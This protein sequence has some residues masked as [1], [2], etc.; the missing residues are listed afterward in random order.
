MDN[1]GQQTAEEA[2]C[3]ID[4]DHLTKRPAGKTH[5][6][7]KAALCLAVIGC[8]LY[9]LAVFFNIL[10]FFIKTKIFVGLGFA[11]FAGFMLIFIDRRDWA[12]PYDEERRGMALIIALSPIL[13][14]IMNFFSKYIINIVVNHQ[15]VID[16]CFIII[17]VAF[18]GA[19]IIYLTE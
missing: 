16:L 11:V 4:A 2:Q 6:L 15:L 10:G 14:E 1:N 5:I 3:C 18:I 9:I 13:G 7:M 8:A 19:L 12:Q 17:L